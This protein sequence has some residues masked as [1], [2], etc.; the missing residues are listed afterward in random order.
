MANVPQLAVPFRVEDGEVAVVEQGS[1]KE[2]NQ[3]IVACLG[4]RLGSRLE[5]PDYGVPSQIFKRQSRSP[6][7]AVF[8]R[9]VEANEPRAALLG[10]PEFEGLIESV[11]IEQERSG[12]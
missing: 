4:T 11:R 8:L 9:A 12:A 10:T 1:R 2:I 6:S 5:A 3:C 7:A